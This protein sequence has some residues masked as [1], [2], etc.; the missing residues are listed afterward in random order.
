MDSRYI[1]GLQLVSGIKFVGFDTFTEVVMK[2]T[3][4]SDR[5][6]CSAFEI[7]RLHGVLYQK[8]EIFIEFVDIRNCIKWPIKGET[9]ALVYTENKSQQLISDNSGLDP[10]SFWR[11]LQ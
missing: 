4:L 11:W 8:I 9:C 2:S 10:L 7:N 1:A 5:T 3:I 6:P